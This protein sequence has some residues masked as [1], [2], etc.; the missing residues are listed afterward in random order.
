L[1]DIDGDGTI[2]VDE[3]HK[4]LQALGRHTSKED[5]QNLLSGVDVDGGFVSIATDSCRMSAYSNR[6]RI[7]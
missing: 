3:I 7:D 1:F 6:E 4:V 5:I 2:T